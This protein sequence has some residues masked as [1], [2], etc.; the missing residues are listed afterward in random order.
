MSKTNTLPKIEKGILMPEPIKKNNNVKAILDAMEVGDSVLVSKKQCNSLR[1]IAWI[2]KIKV[3]T[4]KVSETE[5][6]VWR[7][8]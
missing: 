2:N 7:I 6:R 1:A 3:A 5:M 8:A 4:R